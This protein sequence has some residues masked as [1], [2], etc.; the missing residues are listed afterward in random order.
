MKATSALF[1]DYPRWLASKS[2][3]FGLIGTKH[4]VDNSIKILFL[5]FVVLIFGAAISKKTDTTL[6]VTYPV[7]GGFL[8]GK[9]CN[10]KN[11]ELV[12]FADFDDNRLET[13]VVDYQPAIAGAPKL[14]FLSWLRRF[15]YRCTQSVTHAY[16]MWRFHD[17]MRRGSS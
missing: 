6:Q 14:L 17:K 9:N 3:T 8:S 1:L 16:V 5:G 13:R 7:M 4:D 11:G 10:E 15:I 2:I 12:F